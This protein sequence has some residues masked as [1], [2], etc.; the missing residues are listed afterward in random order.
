MYFY[1]H[2]EKDIEREMEDIKRQI[3]FDHEIFSG[4]ELLRGYSENML[5][6]VNWYERIIERMKRERNEL[7]NDVRDADD[8]NNNLLYNLRESQE[9]IKILEDNLQNSN[10]W[11]FIGFFACAVGS[12]LI[13]AVIF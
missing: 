8:A 2:W 4:N 1:S 5:K 13:G 11:L 9:K 6:L 10:G 7:R 12:F 3:K